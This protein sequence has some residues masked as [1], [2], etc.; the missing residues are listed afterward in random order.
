MGVEE[1][2]VV[3][4]VAASSGEGTAGAPFHRA[5]ARGLPR[6]KTAQTA[7]RV[8]VLYEKKAPAVSDRGLRFC[9]RGTTRYV[10]TRLPRLVAT[11]AGAL[12]FPVADIE[13][14]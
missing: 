10:R 13:A 2:G 3:G 8:T 5:P 4:M 6:G 1:R 12:E 14:G 9:V 11:A 7:A